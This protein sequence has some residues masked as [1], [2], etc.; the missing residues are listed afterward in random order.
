LLATSH[1]DFSPYLGD[2]TGI[3]N[4]CSRQTSTFDSELRTSVVK[5][6]SSEEQSIFALL[7]AVKR[8]M[9]VDD[10][11]PLGDEVATPLLGETYDA[12][13]TSLYK[14][15]VFVGERELDEVCEESRGSTLEQF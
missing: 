13:L 5:V 11:A 6:A 4:M 8:T 15:P 7:L 9:F 14:V 12:E 1:K 3:S 2:P 10:A